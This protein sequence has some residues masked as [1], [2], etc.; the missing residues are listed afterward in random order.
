MAHE[1]AKAKLLA[2]AKKR[3]AKRKKAAVIKGSDLPT[4]REVV[5]QV[6]KAIK[7]WLTTPGL[8]VSVAPDHPIFTSPLF[9]QPD[10]QTIVPFEGVPLTQTPWIPPGTVIPD[11]IRDAIR[12]FDFPGQAPQRPRVRSPKQMIND[13]IQSKAL[14][15]V[16]KKA[17]KKDGSWKQGWNQKRVMKEAQKK[18]T[19]ARERLGLCKRKS[20]RKDQRRKTA[21]RAYDQRLDLTRK[22]RR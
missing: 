9:T 18:C 13:E 8:P 11:V 7:W 22:T 2:S 5:K 3:Q 15:A 10:T 14:T 4:D 17:R 12:G 20:T 21:R 16:N 19:L 6:E 1:A